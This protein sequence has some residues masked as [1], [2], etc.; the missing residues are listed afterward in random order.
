MPKTNAKKRSDVKGRATSKSRAS[1]SVE[2]KNRDDMETGQ[3]PSLVPAKTSRQ[4]GVR[5][6][7]SASP[8]KGQGLITAACIALGCWGFALSFVFTTTDPNRY[9]YGG[10]AGVLAL[11]WSVLFA[12]RLRK[13]LQQR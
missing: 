5:R 12:S 13:S 6:V 2:T 9:L 10:M 8:R 11:M 4:P 1:Q 3:T 7:V